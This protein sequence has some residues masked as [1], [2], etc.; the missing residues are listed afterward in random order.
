LLQ[1]LP[2]KFGRKFPDA[3][4]P[5]RVTVDKYVGGFRAT[6]LIPVIERA[7]SRHVLIAS[8][9]VVIYSLL[10]AGRAGN[11]T[12]GPDFPP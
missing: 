3:P 8:T 4:V 1:E 2:Y 5:N 11:R 9:S 7:G 10:N 12:F 6:G